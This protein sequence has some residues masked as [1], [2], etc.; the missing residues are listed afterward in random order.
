[1]LVQNRP[2]PL[3]STPCGSFLTQIL[4]VALLALLASC[5]STTGCSKLVGG[6]MDM[7]TPIKMRLHPLSRAMVNGTKVDVEVRIEFTDQFGDIGKGVG[8][9]SLQLVRLSTLHPD[10]KGSVLDHWSADILTPDQN[11]PP[12]T[13]SPAPTCVQP[14]RRCPAVGKRDQV[15]ARRRC[16]LAQRRKALRCAHP[17]PLK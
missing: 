17:L 6:G 12:G 16:H 8:G 5:D 9:V 15:A 2:L 1:M 10:H 4:L 3:T 7:F 11:A 14:F 13:P